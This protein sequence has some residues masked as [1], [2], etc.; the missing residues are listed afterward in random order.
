MLW[1]IE[2]FIVLSWFPVSETINCN[3]KLNAMWWV[4]ENLINPYS[5]SRTR[6]RADPCHWKR[7]GQDISFYRPMEYGTICQDLRVHFRSNYAI[8]CRSSK[9]FT[10]IRP[11]SFYKNILMVG[12]YVGLADFD[13]TSPQF[14]MNLIIM[15]ASPPFRLIFIVKNR[16]IIRLHLSRLRMSFK[17]TRTVPNT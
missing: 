11:W 14:L 9:I 10:Q 5:E 3:W 12:F 17:V 13:H 4:L 7:R 6:F 15:H 2:I 8:P 1:I 16:L